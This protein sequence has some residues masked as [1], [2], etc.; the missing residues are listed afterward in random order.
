MF[1]PGGLWGQRPAPDTWLNRGRPAGQ[2]H[3]VVMLPF[4]QPGWTRKVP[5]FQ[6]ATRSGLLVAPWVMVKGHP[7]LLIDIPARR[8]FLFGGI[9]TASDTLILALA[10]FF[11][12]FSLFFFTSLLGR[13]WCGYGCPQTVW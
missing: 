9:F 5:S 13:V 4:D 10:L 1:A 3:R 7:L 2:R 6:T 12:A 11:V 8:V